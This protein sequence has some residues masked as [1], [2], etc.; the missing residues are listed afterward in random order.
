MTHAIYELISGK[1][2]SE[3]K[4]KVNEFLK[5]IDYKQIIKMETI[6]NED[7]RFCAITYLSMDDMRNE[8]IEKVIE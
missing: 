3:L 7:N 2:S 1:N 8:K 5:T 4:R 6:T